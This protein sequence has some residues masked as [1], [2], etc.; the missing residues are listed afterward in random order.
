MLCIR[1][2]GKNCISRPVR[3]ILKASYSRRS[4][5]NTSTFEIIKS[6]NGES[7]DG[8]YLRVNSIFSEFTSL[9]FF[10]IEINKINFTSLQIYNL[11]FTN[12]Y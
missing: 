5:E 1:N 4:N 6:N 10:V 7:V 12:S 9:I 11:Q 2:F 3:L 8:M